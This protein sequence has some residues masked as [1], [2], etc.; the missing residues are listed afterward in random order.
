MIIS[1]GIG[2]RWEHTDK[3]KS[4]IYSVSTSEI[5]LTS[6]ENRLQQKFSLN[7]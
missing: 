7:I 5:N 4:W 1:A 3:D 2:K 6:E